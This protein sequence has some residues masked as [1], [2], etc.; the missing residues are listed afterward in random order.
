MTCQ[1]YNLVDGRLVSVGRCEK[2]SITIVTW[3][4]YRA[5]LVVADAGFD[6]ASVHRIMVLTS[7]AR[8]T[9]VNGGLRSGKHD[10]RMGVEQVIRF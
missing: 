7:W 5:K 2:Y 8:H 3:S 6:C 10:F 9:L 4:R 1:L